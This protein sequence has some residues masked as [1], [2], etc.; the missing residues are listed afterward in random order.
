[1]IFTSTKLDGTYKR[2]M[3]NVLQRRY[4]KRRDSTFSKRARKRGM[5][6]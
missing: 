5:R 6:D 4:T 3:S 1:M 2:G